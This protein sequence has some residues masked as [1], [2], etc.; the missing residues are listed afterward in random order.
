MYFFVADEHYF[1]QSKKN[2]HKGVIHYC[3]RPVKNLDEMHDLLITNHNEIVTPNDTT[4]HL[5]DFS[6]GTKEQTGDVIKKL[7]GNH[8]FIRGCHDR[9]LKKSSPSRYIRKINNI[10]FH[11]EHYPLR[12]W[13]ASY[14]GFSINVHGHCHG[15]M[16]PLP[17]QWDVGVDNNRFFPS[18]A[19]YLINMLL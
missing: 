8:I 17:R 15:R 7:N 11:G 2:S 19:E 9:W 12:S 1:H 13:F 16:E 4:V 14:H 18:S 10:I 5:G 6:F 3:E